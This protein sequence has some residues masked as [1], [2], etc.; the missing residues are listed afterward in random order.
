MPSLYFFRKLWGLWKPEII[1]GFQTIKVGNSGIGSAQRADGARE[2]SELKTNAP[3]GL[4]FGGFLA[5]HIKTKVLC[6]I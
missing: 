1:K 2:R 6:K 3:K 4:S 5:S